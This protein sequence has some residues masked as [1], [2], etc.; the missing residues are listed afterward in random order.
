MPVNAPHPYLGITDLIWRATKKKR[1]DDLGGLGG[2]MM[3]DCVQNLLYAHTHLQRMEM[4]Y[5]TKEKKVPVN[6][7]ENCWDW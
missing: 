3:N 1:Y 6:I 4:L 7:A 5:F 2:G